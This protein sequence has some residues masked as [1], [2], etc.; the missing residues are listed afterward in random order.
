MNDLQKNTV[1]VLNSLIETNEDGRKG[2][3]EAS[4]HVN[5]P[6][7]KSTFGAL[8]TR[9]ANFATELRS[10]VRTL[11]G[12]PESTEGTTG[13]KVHRGW[14]NLKEA[15]TSRDPEAILEECEKGDEHALEQYKEALDSGLPTTVRPIVERQMSTIRETKEKISSLESKFDDNTWVS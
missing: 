7:L 12:E 14:I 9:R 5:T 1:S 6:E 13:G 15:L 11:G 2:Y 10:Q 8:A 3:M 4:E